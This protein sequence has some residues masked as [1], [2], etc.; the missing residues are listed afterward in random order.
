MRQQTGKNHSNT[1]SA[2]SREVYV[3]VLLVQHL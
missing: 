1:K 3:D 2:V